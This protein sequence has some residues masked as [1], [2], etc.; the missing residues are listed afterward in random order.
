MAKQKY[1]AIRYGNFEPGSMATLKQEAQHQFDH[2]LVL[3][4]VN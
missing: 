1:M 4:S 2:T 3:G